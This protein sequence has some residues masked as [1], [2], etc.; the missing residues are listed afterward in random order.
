LSTPSVI[1]FRS[2]IGSQHYECEVSIV[3]TLLPWNRCANF[4]LH[5]WI[6]V[7]RNGTNTNEYRFV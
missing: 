4:W 5:K 7:K 3:S 2:G 6:C 1:A